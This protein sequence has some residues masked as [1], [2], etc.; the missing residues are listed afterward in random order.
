MSLSVSRSRPPALPGGTFALT[1]LTLLVLMLPL[2][3]P[4]VLRIPVAQPDLPAMPRPV[5]PTAY[6]PSVTTPP[7][8]LP[9]ELVGKPEVV[10]LRN[11]HSAVFAMGEGAY[12]LFSELEPLHYQDAAGLWQPISTAFEAAE[13]GWINRS[14]SLTTSLAQHSA[15]AK[16]VAGAAGVAWQPERLLLS[17]PHGDHSLA[18][19][20]AAATPH[21]S[22]DKS[23]VRYSDGWTLAGMQEQWQAR[24]GGSE[25]TYRL[26]TQPVAPAGSAP[27]QLDL[28]VRLTLLPGTQIMVDGAAAALP[29][30]TAA[31][32]HFATAAGDSFTLAPPYA[33]EQGRREIG[34]AG[35]YLLTATADPHVVELRVR[36]P[37]SWLAA[38]ERHYPVIVDPRF[39]VRESLARQVRSVYPPVGFD[40]GDAAPAVSLADTGSSLPRIGYWRTTKYEHVRDELALRFALPM[41]PAGTQLTNAYITAIPSDVGVYGSGAASGKESAWIAPVNLHRISRD[42]WY[43]DN[44][45]PTYDSATLPLVGSANGMEFMPAGGNTP[46][47]QAGLTWDVT[48]L[49]QGWIPQMNVPIFNNGVVLRVDRPQCDTGAVANSVLG[50]C[51]AFLFERDAWSDLELRINYNSSSPG[52]PLPQQ[53]SA[54][55]GIRLLAFYS[56]RTLTPGQSV[57]VQTLGATTAAADNLPPGSS[58]DY[59]EAAHVYRLEGVNNQQWYAVAAR[60]IGPATITENPDDT[61]RLTVP[62]AGDIELALSAPG[63]AETALRPSLSAAGEGN[64]GYMLFDGR[65]MANQSAPRQPRWLHL[66]A[67][68]S[69]NIGAD[70]APVLVTA[71]GY[72]LVMLPETG[73]ITTLLTNK[74][75]RYELMEGIIFRSDELMQ[76]YDLNLPGSSNSKVTVKITGSNLPIEVG[77]FAKYLKAEIVASNG[78]NGNLPG[79]GN[80]YSRIMPV[81]T[82]GYEGS[83]ATFTPGNEN[84][85]LV[86]HYN[87]PSIETNEKGPIPELTSVSPTV[88]APDRPDLPLLP[89]LRFTVTIEVISCPAGSYPVGGNACQLIECPAQAPQAITPR[90]FNDR[91]WLWSGAGWTQ[92]GTTFT[93][94]L[95]DPELNPAPLIGG[96]N[97]QTPSVAVIGGQIEYNGSSLTVRPKAGLAG[98]VFLVSCNPTLGDTFSVYRGTMQYDTRPGV[99]GSTIAVLEPQ[100]AFT[101]ERL[102]D[103]WRAEDDVDLAAADLDFTVR[104]T[105]DLALGTAKLRRRLDPGAQPPTDLFFN[106]RW[107]FTTSGWLSPTLNNGITAVAGN[108]QPPAVAGTLALNLGQSYSLDMQP[109]PN[110]PVLFDK[111]VPRTFES[112]RA[113]NASVTQPADL[114]GATKPVQALLLP[115]NVPRPGDIARQCPGGSCLDV[116]ATND[117]YAAPNRVW[118]MPDIRTSGEVGTQTFSRPGEM[119]VFSADHP[120]ASLQNV[121]QDFSFEAHKGNVTVEEAR[122]V[123]NP[124]SPGYD[125]N[126]GIETVIKGEVRIAIPNIGSS[127]D[128][129]ALIAASFKLCGG[130]LR[131]VHLSFKSPVGVP[132]ATT[133]LFL[134]GISGS[135]DIFPTFTQIR[136]SVTF[137]AAQGGNGGLF[138]ATGEVLIDTRGLLE[139]QGQAKILGT[140]DAEGRLWVAWN[141]LDI[142]LEAELRLGDWLR[143]SMRAHM[144]QGQ[145]WGNKYSWL[146]NDKTTHFSGMIQAE[147]RI[148]EGAIGEV[149]GLSLPPSDITLYGYELAFGEFC[150]NDTCTTYEW[151]VKGKIVVLGFD[152]GLYYGVDEGLDF[153][154][155]NDSHILIDQFGGANLNSPG[156]AAARADGLNVLAAPQA[157]AGEASQT[158]TVAAGVE[159]IMAGFS[160]MAG[161]PTFT[162]I[163]P[164]GVAITPAN[165]AQYNAQIADD[166]DAIIMVVQNPAAGD[167]VARFGNLTGNE[168]YTFLYLANNGAPGAAAQNAPNRLTVQPGQNGRQIITW[169]VPADVQPQHTISLFSRRTDIISGTLQQN[170]PIQKDLPYSQGSYVWDTNGMLN[171]QY[172]VYAIVDDGVNALPTDQITDPDN[173]CVPINGPYPAARAFDSERFPGTDIF[174][175]T[176]TV[177]VNDLIA[178]P[179]P[180]GLQVLADNDGV[181][182]RWQP[183]RNAE[184]GLDGDVSAY[185]LRWGTRSGNTF[186]EIGRQKVSASEQMRFRIGGLRNGSEYGVALSALDANNNVG[187]ESAPVFIT[188]G[189]SQLPEAPQNLARTGGASTGLTVSW[190]APASGPA[191]ARYLVSYL[192]LMG[193]NPNDPPAA[194]QGELVVNGLSTSI[195]GLTSGATY[196]ISVKAR[197]AQNWDGAAAL[198]LRT[199]ISNGV[200]GNSDG[201]PNDWATVFQVSSGS[202]DTDGDLLTNAQE[203]TL[204]THPR[205]QDTDVD[206]KSDGEEAS[207]GTDALTRDSFAVDL[208]QPRLDLTEDS[209]TFHIRPQAETQVSA[210]PPVQSVDFRNVGGGQLNLVPEFNA[211]PWITASVV[212]GDV[213]IGVNASALEPG[214]HAGIIKLN[215]SGSDA[216]FGAARCIRV[217]AWVYPDT[218]DPQ[219][220]PA[221][222]VFLP[223][224]Y[225]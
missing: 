154:L 194:Q 89:D 20:E 97:D 157:V 149:W 171:G 155:G 130:D 58:G 221:V 26:A 38:P 207:A 64:V 37:W 199:V 128:P 90:N 95:N 132:I 135:V 223:V 172:S 175:A 206:G 213:R 160:W 16:I 106:A 65:A 49:A 129:D 63:A 11:S 219:P 201:I 202:A 104:P 72:E 105:Q 101:G 88:L 220:Q 184:G 176:Q 212:G 173:S 54:N 73:A 159:Q 12:A 180:Q 59:Y 205:V 182:A 18:Q 134:T 158:I 48:S 77:D 225:R 110:N 147:I 69:T 192:R 161:A 136:V 111:T 167:W 120:A 116:R 163:R 133:G 108:P 39:V 21:F 107:S 148:P 118:A 15:S 25:Y 84:L 71:N 8:A 62:V 119:L 31:A 78:A 131:S 185:L 222:R 27:E 42:A 10:E 143:G 217:K 93:S 215:Q 208:I 164:D 190:L 96:I 1:M 166:G 33:Y 66:A 86:L 121:S 169:Q 183:Q 44:A 60:G 56:T 117:T 196:E 174:T 177:L 9:P 98:E 45:V 216:L 210:L 99:L 115:R 198:P 146:P 43:I 102:N 152:V 28:L 92:S 85:A 165:A 40:D 13:T 113:L 103:P 36:M 14:N 211:Y 79:S 186:S 19:P 187:P 75:T 141:P 24:R 189:P 181:L 204:G 123:D 109:L 2:L 4:F 68:S 203:F 124:N 81:K 126:A 162:L 191:P 22:A 80:N 145:G 144:W 200:D 7:Y 83:S 156:I 30:S 52:D 50:E 137:Q 46:Q 35:S 153:I 6:Q 34:A 51:R 41:L 70:T 112:V 209:V 218:A 168:N 3:Q 53:T 23:V 140:V 94:V 87:G 100:S 114:G 82:D 76:L 74:Q 195:N 197:N 193:G 127:G 32:I 179:M 57:Q 47:A 150:T 139:F 122:C 138:T 5:D 17:G 151:G 178:P 224:L 188:V 170:L 91:F 125:P 214:F 29:L 61:L 67:N 55:G 142:G